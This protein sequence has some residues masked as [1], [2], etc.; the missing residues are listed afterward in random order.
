MRSTTLFAIG[1]LVAAVGCSQDTSLAR[2]T[3]ARQLA[4]QLRVQ[5]SQ[6]A[7][8]ANRA[9]MAD[10]ETTSQASVRE[11]EQLSQGVQQGTDALAPLLTSLRF[12]DESRL[13]DEFRS[14]FAEY[15]ALDR[16]IL[17]LASEE[18]NLTAQ[19]LSFGAGREA[20][21]AF[22]DALAAVAP[23]NTTTERWHVE[24]LIAIAVLRVREIQVRQ[25]PHIAEADDA[26]MTRMETEMAA[27][28]AAVR[29]A[30][31]TLAS[32]VDAPSR[33]RLATA[34]AALDRFMAVNAEIVALSRRNTNVRSLALSLTRKR[35]VTA[36][37]ENCRL[38]LGDLSEH[39]GAGYTVT[40]LADLV[41]K[42]MRL[43]GAKP[44]TGSGAP[45]LETAEVS[46]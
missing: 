27:S 26:A 43:P 45:N 12:A 25:A 35:L 15:R 7:D 23:G 5:F 31:T 41:V 20:A 42:A 19:R 46:V 13:L 32:L 2:L 33:A 37:C 14:R 38:Q 28:E 17:Q 44:D 39:Y 36:A 22:R 11:A 29:T 18:T 9:V 3:E 4:A 1:A 40:A 16:S 24:A 34:T 21:D 10:T 30:L 6:A 8:A